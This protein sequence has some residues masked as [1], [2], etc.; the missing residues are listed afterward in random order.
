LITFQTLELP[1]IPYVVSDSGKPKGKYSK[2]QL[3]IRG[4]DQIN[5]GYENRQ[6]NR[7]GASKIICCVIQIE[8]FI[9]LHTT[10]Y[11]FTCEHWRMGQDLNKCY[12]NYIL[13]TMW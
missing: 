5:D 7:I 11:V 9:I 6:I 10:V 2:H 12:P 4:W 8:F 13:H 3:V 1:A